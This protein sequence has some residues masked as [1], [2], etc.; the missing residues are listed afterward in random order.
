MQTLL[1]IESCSSIAVA[2]KVGN[3]LSVDLSSWPA[4]KNTINNKYKYQEGREEDR[5]R[6]RGD[7]SFSFLCVYVHVSPHR[8]YVDSVMATF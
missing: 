2:R 7:I 8:T 6:E 5:I 1:L 3:C 4:S